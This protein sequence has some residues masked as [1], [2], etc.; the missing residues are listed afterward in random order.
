VDVGDLS[1][2]AAGPRRTSAF[3]R[4]GVPTEPGHQ[5]IEHAVLGEYD[6]IASMS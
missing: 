6:V 2:R 4:T 1:K 3:P 5:D